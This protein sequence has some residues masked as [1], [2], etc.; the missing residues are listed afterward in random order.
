MYESPVARNQK[1]KVR[2]CFVI[3]RLIYLFSISDLPVN[4]ESRGPGASLQHLNNVPHPPTP[5]IQRGQKKNPSHK[6]QSL[7]KKGEEV[8]VVD[9]KKI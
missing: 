1:Q 3:N 6:L 5:G 2:E 7:L 8:Y 4:Q 9:C